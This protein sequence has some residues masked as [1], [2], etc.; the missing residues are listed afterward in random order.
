[1]KS[2]QA[3]AMEQPDTEELSG[4]ELTLSYAKARDI[5]DQ[6]SEEDFTS[7]GQI[8]A[9]GYEIDKQSISEW[10]SELDEIRK[11]AS[12]SSEEAK[13]YPWPNASNV[14]YPLITQ[15]ALEFSARAYPAL[16]NNGDIVKASIDGPDS[17][18]AKNARKD[19]VT[20]YM[21]YQVMNEM[22]DWEVDTDRMLLAIP[23][24]GVGFKKVYFDPMR[25]VN[26]SEFI[27]ASELVVN[28]GTKSLD[29]V[30]R[31]SHLLAYYP[32]EI[33]ENQG[34][35]LWRNVKLSINDPEV[36]E[37]ENF[38]EQHI[39]YDLDGDGYAEPYIVTFHEKSGEVVR[40]VANYRQ[41]DILTGPDETVVKVNRRAYFVKFEC[42][43]DYEGGFYSK[44]FGS[45]L[46]PINDSV[47]SIL[48]QMIDAGHLANTGG[49]FLGQ[50]FKIKSGSLRFTPGDWKKV[51][52]LGGVL[53]DNVL[54]LPVPQPSNTLF[55]LLG[56]LVESGKG[57]AS[58]QDVMTGGGG[59]N[60]PATSVLA[61]IEQG[62][63]VYTAI[64]KR[65]FRSMKEEFG[66]IYELDGLFL[67]EQKYKEFLDNPEATIADFEDENM[68]ITPQADPRM[69]TDMQRM[70]KA[71]LLKEESALP[72]IDGAKVSIEVMK[73]AGIEEPEQYLKPPQTE[74]SPDQLVELAE[75][76]V[77]KK[78]SETNRIKAVSGAMKN[79]A[80][81]DEKG[82]DN[83]LNMLELI[84][85]KD[86]IEDA[87]ND[88]QPVP[89]LERQ[90]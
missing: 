73:A 3:V 85:A 79:I 50:G 41:E 74:P 24:D 21:S 44:G 40:V 59:Q 6:I 36:Q 76:E 46:K 30:P 88:E 89:G 2:P 28:M 39:L 64:F 13:T 69:A 1:M 26:V 45:L 5:T 19:R 72:W 48:N 8:C 49:G 17:D 35:G 63:K 57:I 78:D 71:A 23:I 4:I 7:L 80:D 12:Q 66:L 68:D 37:P 29:T 22:P 56:M 81:A 14:K 25:G 83:L 42:F 11:L 82:A 87:E 84:T 32:Y 58:I 43:P 38:V 51:E 18:G 33:D 90:Q 15:A 16:I 47:N 70:A 52:V 75:L 62:T 67:D 20:K 34:V 53:K 65:L 77:K 10:L 86:A 31:I 27:S 61:M 54:P 55:A 9:R 60:M